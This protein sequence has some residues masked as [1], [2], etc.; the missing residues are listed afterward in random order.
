[1]LV[2]LLLV[3]VFFAKPHFDANNHPSTISTTSVQEAHGVITKD[4]EGN[5]YSNDQFKFSFKYPSVWQV[6]DNNLGVG[7]LQLFNYDF[8]GLMGGE[9]KPGQNKIELFVTDAQTSYGATSSTSEVIVDGQHAKRMVIDNGEGTYVSYKIPVPSAA[10][11]VL[12]ITIYGEPS[13][14]SELDSIVQTIHWNQ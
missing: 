1:M 9:F 6:G 4:A 13:N 7:T 10:N 5:S 11:K 14:F 12:S 3:V 8:S 2:F